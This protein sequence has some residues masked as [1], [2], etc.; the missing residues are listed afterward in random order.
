M[1]QLPD[2]GPGSTAAEQMAAAVAA[3]DEET[4]APR[5]SPPSGSASGRHRRRRRRDDSAADEAPP[6]GMAA[7]AAAAA[8]E[9]DDEEEQEDEEEEQET[10]GAPEA[11]SQSGRGKAPVYSPL[12][13]SWFLVTKGSKL[14]YY[15]NGQTHVKQWTAPSES[16]LQPRPP[17]SGRR[18]R[19][20]RGGR[21][22]AT[23]RASTG[24]SFA[25]ATPS[26]RRQTTP[27]LPSVPQQSPRRAI[28]TM[29]GTHAS[30]AKMRASILPDS[31]VV[32]RQFGTQVPRQNATLAQRIRARKQRME[33]IW[34]AL[35]L[36]EQRLARQLETQR[37]TYRKVFRLVDADGNGTIDAAEILLLLKKGGYEVNT[38]TFWQTFRELDVDHSSGLQYDEFQD[39]METLAKRKVGV[40]SDLDRGGARARERER[41]REQR[42][43]EASTKPRHIHHM[44]DA[45][46]LEKSLGII[47]GNRTRLRTCTPPE[48]GN[49]R[50]RVVD[51]AD[52]YAD[53]E[54]TSG[55]PQ[56][57]TDGREFM[58]DSLN[59]LRGLVGVHSVRLQVQEKAEREQIV[60]AKENSRLRT[61]RGREALRN[62]TEQRL[63]ESPTAGDRGAGEDL[64]YNMATQD[65]LDA[66]QA[67]FL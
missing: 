24:R 50:I 6:V 51:D 66:F 46:K 15:W 47:A 36:E 48:L 58:E 13:N 49:H 35:R 44:T 5:A 55:S 40:V 22:N 42:E 59:I 12:G 19:S 14:P 30:W 43:Q 65:V 67:I 37:Q 9:E 28:E 33:K 54:H 2:A 61:V 38:E 26:P 41:E 1:Q 8:E 23:G 17:G 10:E 20:R 31:P 7:V 52:K 45:E 4:S 39:A 63:V 18:N 57:P 32:Q 64:L 11:A 29:S 25:K 21:L 16:Q 3:V 56:P 62:E 60:S 34:N 53:V 27:R